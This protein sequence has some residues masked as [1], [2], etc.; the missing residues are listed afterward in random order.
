MDGARVDA[1]SG[2][3]VRTGAT[4]A[5]G[6][7]P[8]VPVRS[9]QRA[10][11]TGSASTASTTASAAARA[12]AAAEPPVARR[13]SSVTWAPDSGAL[14]APPAAGFVRQPSARLKQ[15]LV[16]LTT[17]TDV[18]GLSAVG[19]KAGAAD[20]FELVRTLTHVE[21]LSLFAL[22][23]IHQLIFLA[24]Y[25][26]PGLGDELYRKLEPHRRVAAVG[27]AGVGVV[28]A[29]FLLDA[30][31][32]S[33][34]WHATRAGLVGGAALAVFVGLILAGVQFP[35]VPFALYALVVQA[36][37]HGL[38]LRALRDVS[39]AHFYQA[40]ALPMALGGAATVLAWVVYVG[41][42]KSGW[43]GELKAGYYASVG[44][45][46]DAPSCQVA[47]ILYFA[48]LT[49]GLLNL[50][51]ALVLYFLALWATP[52][53]RGALPSLV[54]AAA[55]L[56]GAGLAAMYVQA[57]VSGANSELANSVLML[58]LALVLLVAVLVGS[59]VG[60]SLM[61]QQLLAVPLVR[62]AA[63]KASESMDAV[64]DL[65][66]VGRAF[67]LVAVF[68]DWAKA[69]L[70]FGGWA[71]FA[72][73]LGVAALQQRVRELAWLPRGAAE[74]ADAREGGV[75]VRRG[76][77]L[78]PAAR[79]MLEFVRAWEWSS[80]LSKAC[81]IGI[82]VMVMNVGFGKILNVVISWLI[83]V[84]LRADVSLGVV[85]GAYIGIGFFLFM[86][87]P[88]PGPA[89]YLMGAFLIPRFT[90]FWAGI[91]LATA[92]SFTLKMITTAVQ[93]VLIGERLGHSVA[94][95][96]FVGYNTLTMRAIRHVLAK[97]GW[98]AGKLCILVGGPDWP[99][100]VACGILRLNLFEILLGNAPQIVNIFA[101]TLAGGFQ[102]RRSEGGLWLTLSS[103]TLGLASAVLIAMFAAAAHYI[104]VAA[105]EHR[106]ALEALP[107]DEAVDR[108]DAQ[109]A[110]AA[111]ARSE[112]LAWSHP[113]HP[114]PRWMR[115]NLLVA[116]AAQLAAVYAAQVLGKKCFAPFEMTDTVS[117]ELGGDW[118]NMFTPLGKGMMLL[119]CASCL[120]LC[121]FSAW[122]RLRV[123]ALAAP[124]AADDGAC[125]PPAD[126]LAGAHR[127]TASDGRRGAPDAGGSSRAR[128]LETDAVQLRIAAPTRDEPAVAR[129]E[130]EA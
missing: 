73:Y 60:W 19:P 43:R 97:P 38:R 41:A 96:S 65:P 101:V 48:P 74:W 66:P 59:S 125:E 45:A 117:G 67:A 29:L 16:R 53:R 99:T 70:F 76:D 124:P 63:S 39:M 56:V 91:A 7:P 116:T 105:L 34:R 106:D 24:L 3:G 109:R 2:G 31:A 84:L 44:C 104:E 40:S 77:A 68:G 102:L 33:A 13:A 9:L 37:L 52:E 11:S 107:R 126:A 5:A 49:C 42:T 86:L 128:A 78:T 98:S 6:A 127:L 114:M 55:G 120:Q 81:T 85:V 22:N 83:E 57:A 90:D 94:V 15:G 95:R 58:A 110:E 35:E 119:W 18:W 25:T 10:P 14:P 87:P 72:L 28:F 64:R 1:R 115:L 36:L 17:A 27:W 111:R 130:S 47:A 80:V 30:H 121:V 50:A 32:W 93:Q 122:A 79:A 69:L 112:A 71:P 113:T 26:G 61:H 75:R 62:R 12:A 21:A 88:V 46:R 82:V 20:A 129:R 108:K 8:P 103:L 4:A 89:V 23:L 123:R 54:R 51:T 100:C 92:L 118:T